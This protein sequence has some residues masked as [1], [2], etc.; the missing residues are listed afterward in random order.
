MREVGRGTKVFEAAPV[1]GPLLALGGAA[2]AAALA[3]DQAAGAVVLVDDPVAVFLRPLY[4][5]LAA[6][7]CTAG[8]RHSHLSILTREHD[9]PCVIA[10]AF[11]DGRPVDGTPVEVDCS[12]DDGVIRA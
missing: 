2:D 6:V 9:V 8:N 12:G 11:P 7:V 4:G 3:A 10:A 5:Q 1:R